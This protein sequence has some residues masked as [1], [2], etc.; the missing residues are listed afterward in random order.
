ME[1]V[2]RKDSSVELVGKDSVKDLTFMCH[3]LAEESEEWLEGWY[4]KLQDEQP[5]LETAFCVEERKRCCSSG[6]FGAQC[7]G[8]PGLV[9][10]DTESKPCFGRGTCNGDG[11]RQGDGKC[12]CSSGYV[13]KMCS[14]CDAH[15]YPVAQNATYI[16]CDECFD[17]CASGCTAAGPKGCRACRSGYKMDEETGCQDI[18]ECQLSAESPEGSEA[19]KCTKDHEVCV[20][21][22]G[23]FRCDCETSFV[24]R[25]KNAGQEGVH[26]DGECELDVEDRSKPGLFPPDT[27]LRLT[28]IVGLFGVS[29]FVFLGHRTPAAVAL[30]IVAVI[31]AF[32]LDNHFE[33]LVPESAKEYLKHSLP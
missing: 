29:T 10:Q 3:Q 26:E 23:S 6:Y 32:V 31:A 33:S 18:D 30:T 16:E 14:N 5:D 22:M 19:K 12:N 11:S 7:S 20:N 1:Y 2:C 24:R 25:G 28:A 21:I 27:A 8:C 13:G 4:F 9:R 17:G 15:Y